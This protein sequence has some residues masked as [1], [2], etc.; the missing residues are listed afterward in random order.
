MSCIQI[1]YES[2]PQFLVLALPELPEVPVG[3]DLLRS[4]HLYAFLSHSGEL[5]LVNRVAVPLVD[6]S[7]AAV[8]DLLALLQSLVGVPLVGDDGQA[9]VLGEA[10]SDVVFVDMAAVE[11]HAGEVGL[12]VLVPCDHEVVIV[13]VLLVAPLVGQGR[14]VVGVLLDR[15]GDSVVEDGRL[16]GEFLELAGGLLEVC[17]LASRSDYDVV[18]DLLVAVDSVV[19][20]V[21]WGLLRSPP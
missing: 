7:E 16:V 13:G 5:H 14:E 8:D 9:V 10:G 17:E 11:V 18:C 1:G 19:L 2:L 12:A 3:L 6:D 15:V 21:R 4:Q 20:C